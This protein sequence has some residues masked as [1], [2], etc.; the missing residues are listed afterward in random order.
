MRLLVKQLLL[1]VT[2]V[3]V[4]PALI[5]SGVSQGFDDEATTTASVSIIDFGVDITVIDDQGSPHFVPLEEYIIGVVLGEVSADFHDEALKA[6]AVSARTYTLYCVEVL[7]K[8]SG[9]AVCTDHRCCQAYCDPTDYLNQGGTQKGIRKV[10][11]AVN[12]TAGQVL[13]YDSQMICATYFASSGGQ[14]EDASEVW[15]GN[16]PYLQSVESPDEEECGY[17]CKQTTYSA[18][19]LQD[20]LGVCL[21]GKPESWFGMVTHTVGGGVDLM[22]IGGK[23]YTG[24]ELRRLLKL[25]STILNVT[26]TDDGVIIDTKG[27]GHRVGMSQHG[28]NAMA[29]GDSNYKEILHHYYADVTLCQMDPPKDLCNPEDGD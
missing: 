23:L 6:Q 2:L 5:F 4:I 21:V 9:G 3:G 1:S 19:E 14:T 20:A 11:V 16:Y 15:E 26:P 13:Q 28:A 29:M 25:R 12:A 22:R 8:H 24:T 17:F 7:K 27:Y 10:Q 18:Q